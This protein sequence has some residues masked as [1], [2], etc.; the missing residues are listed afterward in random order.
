MLSKVSKATFETTIKSTHKYFAHKNKTKLKIINLKNNNNN[1]NNNNKNNFI[2]GKDDDNS[3]SDLNGVI[4]IYKP[5]G[6]TSQDVCRE[7]KLILQPHFYHPKN[8]YIK[9]GHGG[10][11]V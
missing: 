3:N 8:S 5:I 4:A 7:I 1:N 6:L 10:T 11:F 9:I 2:N